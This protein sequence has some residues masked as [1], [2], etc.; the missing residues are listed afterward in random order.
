[1]SGR[2]LV[3]VRCRRKGHVVAELAVT[4]EGRR[5]LRMRHHAVLLIAEDGSVRQQPQP[6]G[7][8]SGGGLWHEGD[9]ETRAAS[10]PVTCAC[11][12]PCLVR[13]A[14]IEAA[15]AAGKSTVVAGPMR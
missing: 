1:V 14:D 2:V 12:R 15:C 3:T 5:F 9:W 7:V 6:S 8:P 11:R 10:Y 13:T 4:G